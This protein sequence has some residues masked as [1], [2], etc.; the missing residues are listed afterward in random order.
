MILSRTIKA[1]LNNNIEFNGLTFSPLKGPAGNIE[2]LFY[3]KINKAETEK[4]EP[5]DLDKIITNVVNEAHGIFK[6]KK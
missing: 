2:F 1:L 3:F 4:N 5:A 6:I